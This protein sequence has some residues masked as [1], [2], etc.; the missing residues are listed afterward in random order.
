MVNV[1]CACSA[2]EA[3]TLKAKQQKENNLLCFP[4][5]LRHV[6]SPH[7]IAQRTF[8]F[9][10]PYLLVSF[11]NALSQKKK[12]MSLLRVSYQ[13]W[14]PRCPSASH[15]RRNP[16]PPTAQVSQASL[17]LQGLVSVK[18]PQSRA[19]H[20]RQLGPGLISRPGFFLL[21]RRLGVITPQLLDTEPCLLNKGPCSL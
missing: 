5:G 15:L 18:S 20:R 2:T 4:S 17:Q 1:A 9:P 6:E 3:Q 10:F 14:S 11:L 21:E 7:R 12:L 8:W 19:F 16:W 13:D